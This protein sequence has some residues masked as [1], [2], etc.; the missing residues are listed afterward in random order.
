M[1]AT[2]AGKGPRGVRLPPTQEA[3]FISSFHVRNLS[4][5]EAGGGS[6]ILCRFSYCAPGIHP[7]AYSS[8]GRWTES[9]KANPWAREQ[10]VLLGNESGSQKEG[11]E[12]L[13]GG[14]KGLHG[15]TDAVTRRTRG[16]SLAHSV[17]SLEE[18]Q[19]CRDLETEKMLAGE[20][21]RQGPGW[22]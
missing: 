2:G 6:E 16:A 21:V 9:R 5:P 4:G 12:P 7:G 18:G 20:E 13:G 8:E 10:H 17:R 11:Q 3:A 22:P 14:L 15:D 1:A 19:R